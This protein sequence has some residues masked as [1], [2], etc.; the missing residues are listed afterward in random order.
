LAGLRESKGAI[1]TGFD[2]DLVIVDPKGKTR[3]RAAEMRSRQRHGALDGKEFGFAVK[4]V[5]L[6]GEVVGGSR[7]P[8]GRMVRPA[9]AGR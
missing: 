3:V 2:A 1:E 6:R 7:R 9:R 4:A 5:F 8:R